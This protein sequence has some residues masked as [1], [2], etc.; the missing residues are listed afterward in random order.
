MPEFI[1]YYD[2]AKKSMDAILKLVSEKKVV[3]LDKGK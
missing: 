2:E 3:Q 1:H